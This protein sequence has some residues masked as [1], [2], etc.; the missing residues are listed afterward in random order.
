MSS[1]RPVH[2][3]RLAAYEPRPARSSAGHDSALEDQ[4]LAAYSDMSNL[5]ASNAQMASRAQRAEHAALAQAATAAAE[6]SAMERSTDVLA[7]QVGRAHVLLERAKAELAVEQLQRGTAQDAAAERAEQLAVAEAGRAR[8]TQLL[9]HCQGALEQ[10]RAAVARRDAELSTARCETDKAQDALQAAQEQLAVARAHQSAQLHAMQRELDAARSA[11]ATTTTAARAS[12]RTAEVAAARAEQAQSALEDCRLQLQHSQADLQ[13][14][15]QQRA[16]DQATADAK[17]DALARELQQ[18]QQQLQAARA[19]ASRVPMLEKSATNAWQA[20]RDAEATAEEANGRARAAGEHADELRAELALA[21]A[22]AEQAEALRAEAASSATRLQAHTVALRAVSQALLR[23][24]AE[25]LHVQ[26]QRAVLLRWALQTAVAGRNAARMQASALLMQARELALGRS[27]QSARAAVACTARAALQRWHQH[28]RELAGRGA[29][30]ELAAATNSS[31]AGSLARIRSGLAIL[32][33]VLTRAQRRDARGRVWT[34]WRVRCRAATLAELQRLRQQLEAASS[35]VLAAR[36]RASAAERQSAE[37][38]LSLHLHSAKSRPAMVDACTE[39]WLGA[40]QR[41]RA[42]GHGTRSKQ[43]VLCYAVRKPLAVPKY[44]APQLSH[45]GPGA[46]RAV[47]IARADRW[48]RPCSSSQCSD[49]ASRVSSE[50]GVHE[51]KQPAWCDVDDVASAAQDKAV[52]FQGAARSVGESQAAEPAPAAATAVATESTIVPK[53]AAARPDPASSTT[54]NQPSRHGAQLGANTTTALQRRLHRLPRPLQDAAVVG[55][56]LCIRLCSFPAAPLASLLGPELSSARGLDPGKALASLLRWSCSL[57]TRVEH[58]ACV[59]QLARAPA[60]LQPAGAGIAG[61][62]H[63]NVAGLAQCGRNAEVIA[64]SIR[65]AVRAA[66]KV[67]LLIPVSEP[68]SGM[69]AVSGMAAFEQGVQRAGS[70]HAEVLQVLAAAPDSLIPAALRGVVPGVSV[71]TAV[72]AAAKAHDSR[73]VKIWAQMSDADGGSSVFTSTVRDGGASSVS[74]SRSTAGR[75]FISGSVARDSETEASD[76][77][78]EFDDAEAELEARAQRMYEASVLWMRRTV[79]LT[80]RLLREAAAGLVQAARLAATL[81]VAEF[82]PGH[83]ELAAAAHARAC[84][85]FDEALQAAVAGVPRPASLREAVDAAA[86]CVQPARGHS[87][88]SQTWAALTTECNRAPISSLSDPWHTQGALLWLWTPARAPGA[89]VAGVDRD[90]AQLSSRTSEDHF[91]GLLSACAAVAGTLPGTGAGSRRMCA[92]AGAVAEH[93]VASSLEPDAVDAPAPSHIPRVPTPV[94]DMLQAWTQQLA[95]AGNLGSQA[96]PS[97]D[98]SLGRAAAHTSMQALPGAAVWQDKDK[99]SAADMSQLVQRMYAVVGV[100]VVGRVGDALRLLQ[101]LRHAVSVRVNEI[102]GDAQPS[103]AGPGRAHGALG[104]HQHNADSAAAAFGSSAQVQARLFGSVS[105]DDMRFIVGEA[106]RI[107]RESKGSLFAPGTHAGSATTSRSAA[108]AGASALPPARPFWEVTSVHPRTLV[109]RAVQAALEQL[110]E[111]ASVELSHMLST[112]MLSVDA[113]VAS[114][115]A[116]AQPA[117][118]GPTQAAR[119][120]RAYPATGCVADDHAWMRAGRAPARAADSAAGRAHWSQVG[121]LQ[122]SA[123]RACAAMLD[124]VVDAALAARELHGSGASL[125]NEEWQRRCR[126]LELHMVE[127]L[128]TLS[129]VACHAPIAAAV[130]DE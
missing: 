123:E 15:E 53:P 118:Q 126:L 85:V 34:L 16:A 73:L 130:L 102:C 119:G 128:G 120:A 28:A 44:S 6:S 116:A 4:L 99:S 30:A 62:R 9:L 76:A 107:A 110:D 88:F 72:A 3:H 33:I 71:D 2:S 91:T 45:A 115:V 36:A 124:H 65:A 103:P 78:D 61:L 21:L 122:L 108:R 93:A 98:A 86:A 8:V 52:R 31:R 32:S 69:A 50:A 22:G 51:S 10:V 121:S 127:A 79:A 12:A 84:A 43:P 58:M 29:Q 105:Q 67:S 95:E 113:S 109:Q 40:P 101:Q 55:L 74:K 94:H 125:D 60:L 39:P 14:V 106:V 64:A 112:G 24:S 11:E 20:A 104:G 26:R 18:L 75:S 81:A 114:E 25:A 35:E 96:E 83:T 1:P 13:R 129:C 49:A 41:R 38:A 92:V 111:G 7:R 77:E 17:Y 59:L 56:R 63:A 70:L 117:R 54:R 89:A 100:L 47:H 23:K 66:A 57:P 48:N 37:L 46:P 82:A 27:L 68:G 90:W 19:E 5:R 87:S 80:Q 42:V 97:A